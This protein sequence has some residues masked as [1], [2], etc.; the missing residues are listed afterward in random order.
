MN[1]F[2]AIVLVLAGYGLIVWLILAI[3][4]IAAEDAER[5][6]QTIADHFDNEDTP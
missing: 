2:V 5:Y 6:D 1:P 3:L 4:A